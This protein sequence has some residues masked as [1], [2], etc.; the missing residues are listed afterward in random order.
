MS[1]LRVENC[2]AV[3]ASQP[4]NKS[5]HILCLRPYA[6]HDNVTRRTVER[7]T[8]RAIIVVVNPVVWNGINLWVLR[9][10][11]PIEGVHCG[12]RS[13]VL[14]GALAKPNIKLTCIGVTESLV[15]IPNSKVV[16]H[17]VVKRPNGRLMARW[18]W[19]AGKC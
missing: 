13:R 18:M 15:R 5:I 12:M 7:T 9:G 11:L 16:A 3:L 2:Q 8:P 14:H 17:G 4:A 10:Q 6:R 19:N 1:G